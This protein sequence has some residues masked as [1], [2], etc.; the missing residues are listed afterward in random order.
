M[1]ARYQFGSS[2]SQFTVQAFA[3]GML[4]FLGHSPTFSVQ[5]FSGEMHLDPGPPPTAKLNLIVQADS[6]T[7]VDRVSASDRRKSKAG[8]AMKYWPWR[9]TRK[10]ASRVP[11]S[12]LGR[13]PATSSGFKSVAD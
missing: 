7:L 10:S 1:T 13:L 4:S 9:N 12:P 8:C 2:R 6:L 3:A 5:E 11:T